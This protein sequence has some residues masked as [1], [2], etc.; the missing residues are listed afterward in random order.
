MILAMKLSEHPWQDWHNTTILPQKDQILH[1]MT[2]LI[3]ARSVYI[4][5]PCKRVQIYRRL[6]S[7]PLGSGSIHSFFFLR[8]KG[9]TVTMPTS[10]VHQILARSFYSY[11]PG[12]ARNTAKVIS[13]RRTFGV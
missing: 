6:L 3:W 5:N 2:I 7:V 8:V 12:Y 11:L 4:S 1:N 13:V 9:T 10:R